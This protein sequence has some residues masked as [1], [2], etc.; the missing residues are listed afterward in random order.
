MHSS[1]LGFHS[2]FATLALSLTLVTLWLLMHGYHGLTGDGQIYAFQAIANL[3]PQ[4]TT[5]L[6]LQNTSQDRFTF[7]SPLYAWCIESLGLDNAARLLTLLFTLWFL[8]AVW[9]FA[10]ALAGRDAAWASVALLMII[11]GNYGGSGVFR[12]LEPFLTARLPAEALIVTALDCQ[13]RGMKWVGLLLAL[14]ALLIHP[15]IA[16]PGLLLVVCLWL[17]IR[18]GII[19][20]I[21][22]VFAI[23]SISVAAIELPAISNVLAVMDTSWLDVVRERSQ[24]LFLQLWSIRDW[25]TNAQPFVYL[26]FTALA[27][28]D[29]RIRKLCAAAAIVGAS[30]LAVAFIGGLIGP[31]AIMVQGQAWRWVWITVLVSVALLPFTALQVARDEKCGPLCALLLVSGCA[32]PEMGGSVCAGLALVLWL[33]RPRI[34]S[35]AATYLKWGAGA[36]AIVMGGWILLKCRAIVWPPTSSSEP[37][38]VGVAQMKDIFALKIPAVLLVALIGWGLRITRR[39]SMA[40]L[41]SAMLA[42]YSVFIFPAAF[43]HPRMLASSANIRE[44]ADWA[45][46]IPPTSTVLVVPPRDVGAF[47]W[48]T[49]ERPNYLTLDQSAGVVFSRATALEVRRRSEVLLPLMDPDWK[50][51]TRLHAQSGTG[52]KSQATTRPLTSKKLMQVCADPQLGF[53]ISPEKLGFDPLPHAH[54]G[55][56]NLWNLYDCRKV[57]SVLSDTSNRLDPNPASCPVR[58]G[59]TRMSSSVSSNESTTDAPKRERRFVAVTLQ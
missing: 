21:G 27:V 23:L 57:R 36:L 24:F 10:R 1:N 14:G 37:T 26:A 22:G 8:A 43:N 18:L 45:N 52:P 28:Q 3:H 58:C 32:L 34:S 50:I 55:G 51:L 33:T 54:A 6:Y 15:L 47:V 35:R 40:V 12:I 53:I 16:L 29:E 19:G 41:V 13:A 9:R 56:W 30:G 42:G 31:V 17:P 48:F 5:D 25:D 20:A 7:F 59:A 38:A 11:E 49:L 44:F 39:T 4:L 46:A 2:T